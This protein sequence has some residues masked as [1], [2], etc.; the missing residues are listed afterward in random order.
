[1]LNDS[2]T[3]LR[4]LDDL[5][6]LITSLLIQAKGHRGGAVDGVS[7]DERRKYGIRAAASGIRAWGRPVIHGGFL[8]GFGTAEPSR[9]DRPDRVIGG[10][11]LRSR[12]GRNP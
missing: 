9:R 8:L 7:P 3:T 10:S 5:I 6:G 4:A 1:L 11:P 2:Q 12:G